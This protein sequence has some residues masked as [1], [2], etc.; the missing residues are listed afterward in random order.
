MEPQFRFHTNV[1]EFIP[2]SVLISLFL[3]G[4]L[5]LTATSHLLGDFVGGDK[6]I[7]LGLRYDTSCTISSDTTLYNMIR[8]YV[9][10]YN[11]R[12]PKTVRHVIL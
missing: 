8:H 1:R 4:D 9:I 3:F 10:E 12:Q 7:W 2:D 6:S 11:T 5:R